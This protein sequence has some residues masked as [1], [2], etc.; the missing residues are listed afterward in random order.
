MLKKLSLPNWNMPPV[1][2]WALAFVC[3]FPWFPSYETI[4][5]GMTVFFMLTGLILND[6][7]GVKERTWSVPV[8]PVLAAGLLF[9]LTILIGAVMSDVQFVTWVYFVFFSCMPFTAMFFLIGDDTDNRAMTAGAVILAVISAISVYALAQ[10]FFMPESLV[11]KRAAR[12]FADPNAL[13]ALFSFGLFG[14]FY[15]FRVADKKRIGM[16]VMTLAFAGSL[17]AGSRGAMGAAFLF[18]VMI[19]IIDRAWVFSRAN[20][21]WIAG[22]L[23]AAFV[24]MV[25][26]SLAAPDRVTGLFNVIMRTVSGETPILSTRL[27]IWSATLSLI[28]ENVWTGIGVG[29]FFLY[30]PALRVPSETSAGFM[31]HNDL[32]QFGAESGIMAPL[33]FIAMMVMM[34]ARTIRALRVSGADD[35]MRWRVLISF[36]AVGAMTL[37][38]MMTF[39]FYILPLMILAGFSFAV[40]HRSTDHILGRAPFP[41]RAPQSLP[42]GVLNSLILVIG[43]AFMT[44]A[45]MPMVSH[46]MTLRAHRAA[47]SGDMMTFAASVNAA[48]NLSLGLNAQAYIQGATVPIGILSL[49]EGVPDKAD[50]EALYKQAARLLDSAESVNP[51]LPSIMFYRAWLAG[52]V[53][54]QPFA[55]QAG[56]E[57][58]WLRRALALDPMHLASRQRLVDILWQSNRRD[59][60]LTLARDGMKWPYGGQN[61]MPYYLQVSHMLLES[62]DVKG[63]LDVVEKMKQVVRQ[64]NQAGP[65]N[66]VGDNG[67]DMPLKPPDAPLKTK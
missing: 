37:H 53:H 16:A 60:A 58:E 44:L 32:L 3:S 35:V 66:I 13:G 62:G 19:A 46:M 55:A 45:L 51:H 33:F 28:R 22:G 5:V 40:W 2:F 25:I 49:E 26:S 9:W 63:H 65:L 47:T 11:F 6:L 12:P 42:P 17:V 24:M 20:R 18:F 21:R 52:L 38:S 48:N 1:V 67:R 56:T 54:G 14:G 4:S 7:R 39:N 64:M 29:T 30:Y 34:I 41:V 61:P 8:S 23:A 31:A 27:D 36:A 50:P 59:E 15:L 10:F 43:I 57:E